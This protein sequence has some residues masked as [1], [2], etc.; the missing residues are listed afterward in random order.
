MRA[1]TAKTSTDESI[2]E[3]SAH[4]PAFKKCTQDSLPICVKGRDGCG[5]LGLVLTGTEGC[6]CTDCLTQRR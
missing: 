5:I 6:N 4:N 1:R 3:A 2:E